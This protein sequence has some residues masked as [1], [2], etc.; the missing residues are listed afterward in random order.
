MIRK[1]LLNLEEHLLSYLPDH[2]VLKEEENHAARYQFVEYMVRAALNHKNNIV[3]VKKRTHDEID[4]YTLDI[5][6]EK[7]ID[8]SIKYLSSPPQLLKLCRLLDDNGHSLLALPVTEH[9]KKVLMDIKQK[10]KEKMEIKIRLTLLEQEVE[11][12]KKIKK[13]ISSKQF[14]INDLRKVNPL[15][16]SL[17]SSHPF[18]LAI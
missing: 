13:D 11:R 7:I 15:P 1:K 14:E 18:L 3:T 12:L 16:F 6:I 2:L 8:E 5:P 9:A 10:Y 4:D 17:S